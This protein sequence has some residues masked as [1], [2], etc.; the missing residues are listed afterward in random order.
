MNENLSTPYL[1]VSFENL[2]D[3]DDQ[4]ILELA[5]KYGVIPITKDTSNGYS[6]YFQ[7]STTEKALLLFTKALKR[8][9][10]TFESS[11]Q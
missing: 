6:Y 8:K 3:K 2:C 5:I 9:H 10:Y 4:I 7:S 11:M 1:L